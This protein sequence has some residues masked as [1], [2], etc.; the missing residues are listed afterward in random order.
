MVSAGSRGAAPLTA[1]EGEKANRESL[2]VMLS[3]LRPPSVTRGIKNFN[4]A[5]ETC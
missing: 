1:P 5:S 2:E 4:T 3:P